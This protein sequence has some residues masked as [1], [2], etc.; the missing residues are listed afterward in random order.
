MQIIEVDLVVLVIVSARPE[1]R[2]YPGLSEQILLLLQEAT[3]LF[4]ALN[5]ID[6]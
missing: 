6:A 4:Y 2:K 3:Q 5:C 1:E